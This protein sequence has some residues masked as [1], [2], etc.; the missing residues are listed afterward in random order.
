MRRKETMLP[1]RV[2][3]LLALLDNETT[4]CGVWETGEISDKSQKEQVATLD[5]REDSTTFRLIFLG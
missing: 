4:A 2:D 1:T 5:G 3:S